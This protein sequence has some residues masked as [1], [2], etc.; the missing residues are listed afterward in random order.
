MEGWIESI[1]KV[2]GT[3][4]INSIYHSSFIVMIKRIYHSSFIDAKKGFFIE[5]GDS[6]LDVCLQL[7]LL[8]PNC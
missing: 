6:L 2:E 3:M 4:M 8:I 7:E 5:E 1:D